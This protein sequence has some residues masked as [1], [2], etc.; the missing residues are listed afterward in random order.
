MTPIK[1]KNPAEDVTDNNT[2]IIPDRP[3]ENLVFKMLKLPPKEMDAYINI[4][5]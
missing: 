4:T 2:M 1:E 5:R 3:K